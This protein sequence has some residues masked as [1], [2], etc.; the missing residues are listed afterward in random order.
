MSGTAAAVLSAGGQGGAGLADGLIL[1][2]VIAVLAALFTARFWRRAGLM[3][4]PR[5]LVRVLVGVVVVLL[6]LWAG[7]H[8]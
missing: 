1:V 4:T 2:A 5:L 8:T 7:S 3:L 6:L